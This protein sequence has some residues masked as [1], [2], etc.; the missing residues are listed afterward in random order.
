M[1]SWQIFD[2]CN[3]MLLMKIEIDSST[4]IP[5]ICSLRRCFTLTITTQTNILILRGV[6]VTG[7]CVFA[8]IPTELVYTMDISWTKLFS[9]TSIIVKGFLWQPKIQHCGCMHSGKEI[10]RAPRESGH[11]VWSFLSFIYLRKGFVFAA[12][13]CSC[14]SQMHC[15]FDSN[16][17]L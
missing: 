7:K 17:M 10:P 11:V 9:I 6:P 14:I 5:R 13:K 3:Y 1:W 16:K 8:W 12:F 15:R 4:L 2:P